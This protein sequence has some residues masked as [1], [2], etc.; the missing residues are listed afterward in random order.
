MDVCIIGMSAC[1][2]AVLSACCQAEGEIAFCDRWANQAIVGQ[3]VAPAPSES[4]IDVRRQWWGSL[5]IRQS[6]IGTPLCIGEKRYDRGLGSHAG[7]ELVVTLPGPAKA[8]EAEAG[9]DNNS[10][11][12]GKSAGAIFAVR[13]SEKELFRS[14][15]CRCG[16]S[17]VPVEVDVGGATQIT[18]VVD[19]DGSG[20]SFGHAD[21]ADASVVLADGKR[22]WLDELPVTPGTHLSTGIPFSFAY[23]GKPSSELLPKWKHATRSLGTSRHVVTYT[24]PK[25]SLE[26]ACDVKILKDY[27]A[28]EWVLRFTN[29]GDTDTPII[30]SILP[31]DLSLSVPASDSLT[32]HTLRGSDASS[33]DFLPIEEVI[34]A[35]TQKHLAPVGGRSSNTAAFP[36]FNLQWAEGG[37]VGA[38]GWSGQWAMDVSRG[39]G[40]EVSLR[41]G[42][43]LTHFSLHPG[44]SVRTPRILLV[45]WQGDD[46]MRGSNLL[47]RTLLAH[48]VPER[49]GEPIPAPV[50]Q[51]TWF[52]YNEGNGTTEKNQLEAQQ[53]MKSIGIE[54]YWLDAGWFEGGW[55]GGA[56]SW[57]PRKDNYPN[58]LKPLGDAAH[59]KGMQFVL[60]FEP[61]RV[62]PVS[63]IAKEHPEWVL[64]AGDGDGLFN[65]GVPS[66]RQWLTDYLSKCFAD[67][68]VDIFRNDFNIDPLRFWRAADAPDR[69]GIAEIRY[70]EGLYAM[71][72]EL[73]ARKPGLWI[74]NCASGGR[75]ID[76]ETT[77]RSIPLWRSDSQCCGKAM[78]VQ[79]QVQTAGLSQYVPIHAAGVWGTEPYVFRSAATTGTNLCMDLTAPDFDADAAKRCIAEMR[80]LRSWYT[81]DFYPLT[82]VS[83]DES[84]WIAWQFDRPESGGGFALFFRRSMSPYTNAEFAL[85]GLDPEARYEVTYVD[86]Q[87]TTCMTG[88]QLESM[89]VEIPKLASSVL[90]TY[91]KL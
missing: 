22:I 38:I 39:G 12:A 29:G 81:G 67:W 32:L 57:V 16:Q 21:W 56:G 35:G 30:D 19:D 41:A 36:F 6:V 61:E 54:A 70:M 24:D 20:P 31:L 26:V 28:V 62:T 83:L 2:V 27:P 18:L 8:F 37:V 58:G 91:R 86:A 85:R 53:A 34:G 80:S 75:R 64:H 88:K 78:P 23:A 82:R 77:M 14:G 45:F 59:E 55:P 87:R 60:W 5:G 72:D 65:L 9:I 51:N 17:P 3:T 90:I 40:T 11:T 73:R 66:A 43:E 47:R 49:D 15:I 42:Q 1:F 50:T 48:Y 44:E 89:Q 7:S 46:R 52:T 69:Q 4:G 13:A 79:D 68:G 25:T 10:H 76:L 33:S 63:L 74:D 84:Q 71:W